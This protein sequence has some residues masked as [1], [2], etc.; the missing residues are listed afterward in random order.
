MSVLKSGF[1]ALSTFL[2]LAA[3]SS[4]DGPSPVTEIKINGDPLNFI[5]GTKKDTTSGIPTRVLQDPDQEWQVRVV[6]LLTERQEKPKENI[7]EGNEPLTNDDVEDTRESTLIYKISK[8]SANN[9]WIM[10]PTNKNNKLNINRFFFV[11]REGK[12]FLHSLGTSQ[13]NDF[14]FNQF[15][16]QHY[17][18]AQDE[19]S[20]SFLFSLPVDFDPGIGRET[21][22]MAVYFI[23]KENEGLLS[24]MVNT[25]Y[26][27]LYGP[28]VKVAWNQKRPQ[29][30]LIC[31]NAG[32]SRRYSGLVAEA[33][34]EWKP[35]LKDRLDFDYQ[36]ATEACPPFSDIN[37]QTVTHAP[38]IIIVEG[39]EDLTAAVTIPTP[40]FFKSEL[41]DSDI[42]FIEG[43][44]DELLESVH[45][46]A[47]LALPG[48][49]DSPVF[50]SD[51]KWT[52]VH[53][54]GHYLG[55]H[56]QFDGTPSVMAYGDGTD[57]IYTYDRE[58]LFELYPLK[59]EPLTPPLAE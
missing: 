57:R 26:N 9:Q 10:D 15:T 11:E 47:S 55:L 30:L 7:E 49:V 53:E 35:V 12:L 37:T 43:E 3:C 39:P 36:F 23:K 31:G 45:P 2:L 41:L 16:P 4:D 14:R 34:T 32:E 27:Y 24:Q 17:S 51:Y 46:D 44:W 20:F 1:L 8:D 42:W 33:A 28:G 29:T 59:T 5:A 48:L 13:A 56:H 19:K 52:M 21:L 6:Q 38:D 40:D 22:L 58:A 18:L 25:A 54:I 50:R